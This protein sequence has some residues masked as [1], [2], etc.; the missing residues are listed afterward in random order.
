MTAPGRRNLAGMLALSA[1]LAAV[2]AGVSRNEFPPATAAPGAFAVPA[3]ILRTLPNG[4]RVLVIER[5]S[6]PLV[7][8]DAM[9]MAGA[10]HDPPGGA[11]T[12]E[13]VASLLTEGTE[14]R[15][16]MDM[17]RAIDQAGGTMDT[18]AGWDE[19]MASVSVLA[20]RKALAFDLMSDILIHPA[21]G[22]AEI[23]RYRR[24]TISALRILKDDPGYVAD[25]VVRRALLAGTPYAH[26]PEGTEETLDSITRQDLE[27]FYASYYRPDDTAVAVLGDLTP[28]EGF[29]LAEK[30]FGGWTGR[31][32]P[33][34]E[35]PPPLRPKPMRGVLLINKPDAVQTEIRIGFPGVARSSPEYYALKVANQVLGGAAGNRLFFDLR[36][37]RGLTYSASSSLHFYQRLGDWV[38][39]S[40]T[41]AED[42]VKAVT[43][44]AEQVR[45]MRAHPISEAELQMAQN[46]LVGHLALQ[47]EPLD[48]IADHA[49]ELILYGLPPDYWSAYASRIRAVTQEDVLRAASA[50]LRPGND[51]IVLVGNV[52]EDAKG[53]KKL[54]PVRVI[55]LSRLDLGSGDLAAPAPGARAASGP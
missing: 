15:S 25:A 42:T 27:N 34:V 39:K 19:T 33:S 50:C 18:G 13:F 44:M 11:G 35:N 6:V 55:P 26:P 9:V 46:Y 5:R 40:S 3:P 7:R 36:T 10:A 8:L 41:R 16:A 38:A 12:A 47:F 43:Q 24:Q 32:S 54:G 48:G 22:P 23:E 4:L 2:C 14:R 21:F 31:E 1:G 51:V 49:L 53:L 30:F 37:Q 17:A 20:D 52:A 29:G 45:L 28:Q